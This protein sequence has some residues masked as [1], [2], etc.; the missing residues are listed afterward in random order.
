[1][2]TTIEFDN[3]SKLYRLGYMSGGTFTS[4]MQS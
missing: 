4:D 2:P 3:I 1:M